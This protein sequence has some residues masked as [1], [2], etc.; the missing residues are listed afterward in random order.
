MILPLHGWALHWTF[1][2]FCSLVQAGSDTQIIQAMEM[3]QEEG[4]LYGASSYL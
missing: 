1:Q 4:W 3:A 2:T